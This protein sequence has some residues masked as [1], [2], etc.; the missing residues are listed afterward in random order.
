VAQAAAVLAAMQGVTG[1]LRSASRRSANPCR[2]RVKRMIEQR[3]GDIVKGE[4]DV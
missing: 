1:W 2:F 3:L 4:E